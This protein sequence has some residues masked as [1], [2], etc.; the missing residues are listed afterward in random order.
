MSRHMWHKDLLEK[1]SSLTAAVSMRLAGQVSRVGTSEKFPDLSRRSYAIGS[2]FE[3]AF[4]SSHGLYRVY[5]RKPEPLKNLKFRF[6][7]IT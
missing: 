5:R 2:S 7:K 1:Q 6:W 4:H 3:R